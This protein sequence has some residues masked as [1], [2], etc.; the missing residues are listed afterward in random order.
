MP[1]ITVGLLVIQMIMC[2]SSTV[3][4][5]SGKHIPMPIVVV[6]L[7]AAVVLACAVVQSTRGRKNG[8]TL[9]LGGSG[10]AALI[11]LIGI[12]AAPNA[13]TKSGNALLFLVGLASV[14]L[15]QRKSTKQTVA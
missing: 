12:F 3:L 7:L 1:Y 4:K 9:A 13:P 6:S 5:L 11:G 10:L 15:V 2:A 8:S 14:L